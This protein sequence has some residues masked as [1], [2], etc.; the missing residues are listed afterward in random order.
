MKES[1][2]SEKPKEMHGWKMSSSSGETVQNKNFLWIPA[3][4]TRHSVLWL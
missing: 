3:W 2:T 1:M 4:T